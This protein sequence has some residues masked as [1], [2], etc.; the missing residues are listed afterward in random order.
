M[1]QKRSGQY[2]KAKKAGY[3][4]AGLTAEQSKRATTLKGKKVSAAQLKKANVLKDI[5]TTRWEKG[6]GVVGPGGKAF[7]GS[8]IL[9][10]GKTATYVK[11]RRVGVQTKPR[12]GGGTG[13]APAS[14]PSGGG[15]TGKKPSYRSYTKSQRMIQGQINKNQSAK[16]P[17]TSTSRANRKP[18]QLPSMYKRKQATPT[19][20]RSW[21]NWQPSDWRSWWNQGG[22]RSWKGG[23]NPTRKAR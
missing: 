15:D 23:P 16:P 17:S 8:V 7:T 9:A 4:V 5:G 21:V 13:S 11:G 14:P 10:S 6:K 19:S 18:S 20:G 2:K 12:S 1:E 3:K 22:P